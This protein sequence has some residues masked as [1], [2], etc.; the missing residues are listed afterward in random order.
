[1][2]TWKQVRSWLFGDFDVPE[3]GPGTVETSDLEINTILLDS[4]EAIRVWGHELSAVALSRGDRVSVVAMRK[5]AGVVWADG[6][7]RD[8]DGA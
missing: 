8:A 1:M 7:R 4:G 2:E 5:E 3:S 6:L